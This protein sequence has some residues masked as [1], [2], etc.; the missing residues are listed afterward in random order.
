MRL[1]VLVLVLAAL[2]SPARAAACKTLAVTKDPSPFRHYVSIQKAV[3]AAKP[4]DWILVAPGIYRESVTIKENNRHLRG[5]NRSTV[6]GDGGHAKGVDGIEVVKASNVWIE[7]LAVRNFDRAERDGEDGNQ[8]WWNGGDESGKVGASGWYGS[9]LTTYDDGLLGG[10]GLFVSN[11]AKG[12]WD[13]V[14][15]SGFNDSGLYVGAC[16]DC[17]GVISHALAENNALGYSG[18][19]SGGH[20][21]VQDS[22]FRSNGLGVVPN[23][24][25]QDPPPPQLGTCDAASNTTP[26]PTIASTGVAR[27]TKIGR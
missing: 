7:S 24:L 20:L 25:P 9:Y 27:C 15:A 22:V 16:P 6:V 10:Y 3:N 26:T 17:Q 1:G 4:C 21:V 11:S 8:I 5:L 13:H 18:T 23:S 14:Y 12:R 19:N 2:A